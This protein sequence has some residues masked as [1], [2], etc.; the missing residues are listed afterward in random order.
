L[1]ANLAL[2][3][4]RAN[5]RPSLENLRTSRRVGESSMNLDMQGRRHDLAD[6][7]AIVTGASHG[8][9]AH[10]ARGLW[11]QGANLLLVARSEHSLF[12]LRNELMGEA[13]QG[14]EV[15]VIV[16]DLNRA[17]S[18]PLILSEA[19]ESWDGVDILVNNAGILGPMGPALE[20]KPEEWQTTF[21]IN[22]MAPVELCQVCAAWM[23]KRR[24]GK[25]VNLSGGGATSPRPR[26]SA[27][28]AAKTALVRFSETF[29]QELYN[30]NVHVNCLA[31]GILNTPMLE[32]VVQAGPERAGDGEYRRALEQLGTGSASLDRAADL[33]LFLASPASD[34][35]TG[36][37]ISATWDPW[38]SL[39][40]HLEDLKDSDIYTLRRITPQDR[41]KDWR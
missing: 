1:G 9:G 3:N 4:S 17:D 6:K 34:G 35:I 31:P 22:L 38:E 14:Q 30:Y 36:R 8:L 2:E 10:I 32:L 19:H 23:V 29:A 25:I 5:D 20:N 24:Q 7:N 16:V 28:A 12:N 26:F 27:Y 13:Q 33:C 41:G 18:V 39:P 11:R 15:R 21:R 37:L 40:E